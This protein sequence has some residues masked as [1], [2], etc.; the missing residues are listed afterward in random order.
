MGSLSPKRILKAP[1]L[2]VHSKGRR[3]HGAPLPGFLFYNGSNTWRC[4]GLRVVLPFGAKPALQL[5]LAGFDEAPHVV[6]H[7]VFLSHAALGGVGA[8]GFLTVALNVRP[9]PQ[10]VRTACYLVRA[11]FF[12]GFN[13]PRKYSQSRRTHT[14]GKLQSRNTP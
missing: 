5:V 9:R 10:Q 7:H 14:K 2:Q 6:P 13:A 11:T 12:R 1:N 8:T 3:H 4:L